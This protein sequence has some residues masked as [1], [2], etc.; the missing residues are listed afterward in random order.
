M[1]LSPAAV[2]HGPFSEPNVDAYIKA[3]DERLSQRKGYELNNQRVKLTVEIKLPA[4][5]QTVQSLETRAIPKNIVLS[6][7]DKFELESRYIK[8]GW[9]SVTARATAFGYEFHLNFTPEMAARLTR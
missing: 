2:V 3:I 7:A 9:G 4:Q 5:R 6:E 8:A 1:P